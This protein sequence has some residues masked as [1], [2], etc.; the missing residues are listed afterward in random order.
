MALE[1]YRDEYLHDI[2]VLQCIDAETIGFD[3]LPNNLTKIAEAKKLIIDKEAFRRIA[4]NTLELAGEKCI[5]NDMLKEENKELKSEN[6][7]YKQQLDENNVI[8]EDALEKHRKKYST[9][10][11]KKESH[12]AIER[13]WR[14]LQLKAKRNQ[15]L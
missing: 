14:E 12:S 5:E 7:F 6:V 3:R 11:V 10:L 9:S 4:A 1:A 2:N 8:Y 15:K 13:G